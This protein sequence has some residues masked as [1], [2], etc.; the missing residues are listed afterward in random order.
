[1][2]KYPV[3]HTLNSVD[4]VIVINRNLAEMEV[5]NSQRKK[6]GTA[7]DYCS[8]VPFPNLSTAVS[9]Q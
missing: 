6:N 8:L 7:V 3:K 5:K 4:H 9:D 1:M 2:I